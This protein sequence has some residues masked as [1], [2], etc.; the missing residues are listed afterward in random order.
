MAAETHDKVDF[1]NL[2]AGLAASAIAVLSQVEMLMGPSPAEADGEELSRD[3]IRKRVSDGLGG[4]RQLIDT[5]AVLDEKTKGNLT[6]EEARFLQAALSDLRIRYVS[7][8][9]RPMPE[10][11]AGKGDGE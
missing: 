10:G 5:L 7:L 6:D 4:A 1:N 3:E 2:V 8:A 9:N 11:D